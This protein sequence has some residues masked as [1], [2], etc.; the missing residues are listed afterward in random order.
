[1]D[2]PSLTSGTVTD[3]RG[4]NGETTLLRLTLP[5]MSG[6]AG[7]PV[8]SAGGTVLGMLQD[9]QNGPRQ[10]PEDVSFAVTVEAML[11]LLERSGVWSRKS[12]TSSP[13]ANT[14]RAQTA[15]D[16]TA[17]VSCWG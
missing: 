13:V 17:L 16:I 10:L 5:A 8:L 9:P 12:E 6:D 14:A 3:D 4:L 15:R 11:A 2:T 1:L 7:G